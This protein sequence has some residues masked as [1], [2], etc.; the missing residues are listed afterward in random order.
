MLVFEHY[1]FTPDAPVQRNSAGM[2]GVPSPNELLQ[3][4]GDFRILR[5]GEN[6]MIPEWGFDKPEMLV[7]MLAQKKLKKSAY[8]HRPAPI[9]YA[10]EVSG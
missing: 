2:V 6:S 10:G 1:L 5:Y 3:I 9:R 8:T 4:F 7:R